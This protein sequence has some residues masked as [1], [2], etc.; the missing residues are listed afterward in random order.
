MFFGTVD[1]IDRSTALVIGRPNWRRR[2]SGAKSID[3]HHCGRANYPA[4]GLRQH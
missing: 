4:D 3:R 1:F 2:K